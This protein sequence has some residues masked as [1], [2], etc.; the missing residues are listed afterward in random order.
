MQLVRVFSIPCVGARIGLS[1]TVKKGG[2]GDDRCLG[3]RGR[4]EKRERERDG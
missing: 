3:E 2:V 4:E 1:L